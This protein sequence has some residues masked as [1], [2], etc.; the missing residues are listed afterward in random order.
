M[1]VIHLVRPGTIVKIVTPHCMVVINIVH[2]EQ[3]LIAVRQQV[4]STIDVF[5][6]DTYTTLMATE[7]EDIR[8]G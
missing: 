4:N 1:Q 5:E 2:K 6:Y 8:K 3:S 7:K